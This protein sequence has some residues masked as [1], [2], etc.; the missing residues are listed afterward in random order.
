MEPKAHLLPRRN[1]RHDLT[2]TGI[3]VKKKS[4]LVD[5]VLII[6][7]KGDGV[8]GSNRAAAVVAH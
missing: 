6:R 5:S 1:S 7:P 4:L 8:W 2:L 3:N